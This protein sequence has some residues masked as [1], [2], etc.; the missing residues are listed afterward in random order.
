VQ[1]GRVCDDRRVIPFDDPRTIDPCE[2]RRE[3]VPDDEFDALLE[4]QIASEQA[5]VD[6][7]VALD[8]VFI[9]STLAKVHTLQ[10]RNNGFYWS[11][12][13]AWEAFVPGATR[14]IWR[15]QLSHGSPPLLP[16]FVDR[17]YLAE[18]TTKYTRCKLCAPDVTEYV[19]RPQGATTLENVREQMR[20]S[21]EKY[22]TKPARAVLS[23]LDLHAD[24]AGTCLGCR[25]SYPCQT[26]EAVA[27]AFNLTTL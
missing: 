27:E 3:L 12:R 24:E 11:R 4:Q 17:R 6:S 10:C 1:A 21:S 20:V 9:L 25:E 15:E 23:V 18:S 7:H 19:R 26:V 13:E 8:D 22:K 16:D 2:R 14:H 5:Y